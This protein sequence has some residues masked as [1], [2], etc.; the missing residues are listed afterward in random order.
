MKQKTE[1]LFAPKESKV[2]AASIM[3]TIR[4]RMGQISPQQYYE[5]ELKDK[6]NEELQQNMQSASVSKEQIISNFDENFD[7]HFK[8]KEREI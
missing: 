8:N 4:F 5:L 6:T 2:T 1:E 3:R 7:T